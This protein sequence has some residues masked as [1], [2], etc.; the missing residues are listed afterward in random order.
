MTAIETGDIWEN[1]KKPNVFQTW[2]YRH[3]D[4]RNST[5]SKDKIYEE[6]SKDNNQIAQ[7][8]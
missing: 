7:N 1:I 4:P 5:N 8:Q 3:T 2:N 6:N